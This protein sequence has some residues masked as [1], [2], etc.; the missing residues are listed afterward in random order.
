MISIIYAKLILA[1]VYPVYIV[2]SIIEVRRTLVHHYKVSIL[3]WIIIVSA[4]TE[5]ELGPYK[6]MQPTLWI[7]AIDQNMYN[8]WNLRKNYDQVKITFSSSSHT[9]L[10]KNPKLKFFWR[11]FL[12]FICQ[13]ILLLFY[14]LIWVIP[15][16]HSKNLLALVKIAIL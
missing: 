13:F 16:N 15:P 6:L 4:P 14:P 2:L 1:K 8:W 7:V 11:I 10:W 3:K 12:I 9:D 5:C